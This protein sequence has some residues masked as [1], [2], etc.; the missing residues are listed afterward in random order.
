MRNRLPPARDLVLAAVAAAAL[1]VEGELR[2][3]GG[4]SPGAYLLAIAAAAP[5]A[6]PALGGHIDIGP[7]A[8]R[9]WRVHAVFPLGGEG[10]P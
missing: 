5:L 7:V 6:W 2:S 8:Q 4:L 3:S 1:I 10:R 9:G